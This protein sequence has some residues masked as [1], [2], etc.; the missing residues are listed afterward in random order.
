MNSF[1]EKTSLSHQHPQAPLPRAARSPWAV[2]GFIYV[3]TAFPS[4]PCVGGRAIGM[5][6]V[7]EEHSPF[8]FF[9]I[10]RNSD[11]SFFPKPLASEMI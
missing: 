2:F 6:A 7:I 4:T 11:K 9:D 3:P 10:I 8:Y 5:T 1:R